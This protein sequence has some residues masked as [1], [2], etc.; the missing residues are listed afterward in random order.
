MNAHLSKPADADMLYTTLKSEIK[1]NG[2]KG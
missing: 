2:K 1:R